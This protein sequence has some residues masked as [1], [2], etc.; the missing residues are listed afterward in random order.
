VVFATGRHTNR[1][2]FEKIF[3]G[4]PQSYK[5]VEIVI[6]SRNGASREVI[7][8]LNHHWFLLGWRLRHHAKT[9]TSK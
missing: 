1:F 5:G 9:M 7:G 3:N 8:P 4:G 2:I 6:S